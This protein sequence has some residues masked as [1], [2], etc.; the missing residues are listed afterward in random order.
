MAAGL[1]FHDLTSA[2]RLGDWKRRVKDSAVGHILRLAGPFVH[3]C[4]RQVA[5]HPGSTA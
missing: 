4:T 2:V 1:V 5:A 3:P